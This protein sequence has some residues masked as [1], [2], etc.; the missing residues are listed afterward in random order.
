MDAYAVR[1]F[2]PRDVRTTIEALWQRNLH[3]E[4][5]A[6]RKFAWLYEQAPLPPPAVFVLGV[7]A[8][9]ASG[10]ALDATSGATAA[11]ALLDFHAVGTAGVGLREIA[12][13][14][15]RLRA[16]L[17]ADLAVDRDHR[18]VAPALR[19][20]REVKA[21]A[22]GELD[23][24][25]GFPN[26]HARGV[27]RRVGYSALG[28]ICRYVRVLRHRGYLTKLE[29]RHFEQLP[30]QLRSP[31][32][33]ALRRDGRTQHLM[34]AAVDGVQ[35]G[36]D[37]RR[38]AAARRRVR[39]AQGEQPPAGVDALWRRCSAEYSFVAVRSQRFLAWRYPAAPGRCWYAARQGTRL[40][41]YA[42]VDR[43]GEVAYVRDL[44]GA[45]SAVVALLHQLV[46][47]C[48][49]AG[50]ASISMRYLGDPWLSAALTAARFEQRDSE[51]VVFLSSSPRLSKQ[52]QAM[53]ADPTCWYI[54]DLDEDI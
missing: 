5:S 45:R 7:T 39:L 37:L 19:L 47:E 44:F 18:T 14:A 32:Q 33:R 48:Y 54:T 38:V 41:A 3:L 52:R 46:F 2:P 43:V 1:R 21:W 35:L 24:A 11:A 15:E 49:R 12:L 16:G 34:A 40:D 30:P 26:Q 9:Q 6:E 23:L 10:G 53:L 4:Q 50:A 25:Y 8:A 27:F 28:P 22:L 17:L 42:L 13:G 31:A 51:R 29:E 20:V 36:R